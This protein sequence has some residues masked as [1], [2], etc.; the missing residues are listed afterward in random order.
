MG[1]VLLWNSL[2]LRRQVD[3]AYLLRVDLVALNVPLAPHMSLV[4]NQ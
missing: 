1:L 4:I 3:D 2:A